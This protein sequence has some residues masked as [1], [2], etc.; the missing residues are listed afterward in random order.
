MDALPA[1]VQREA[2]ALS[3]HPLL[4]LSGRRTISRGAGDERSE[5]QIVAAVER[6]FDD[7]AILDDG[8]DRGVLALQHRRASD[9]FDSV[10]HLSDLQRHVNPVRAA[11]Q[12]LYV[13]ALDG[14]EPGL[15]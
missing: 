8:S 9:Y 15:L 5:L 14:A 7:A 1:D 11:D 6:Q 4:A 13:P 12:N 10:G 2:V 3:A